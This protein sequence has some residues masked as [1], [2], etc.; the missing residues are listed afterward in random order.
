MKINVKK[1]EFYLNKGIKIFNNKNDF[2]FKR[3]EIDINILIGLGKFFSYK[4]KSACYWEL[5]LKEPKY[6]F[7][8]KDIYNF[9]KMTY[10]VAKM[11]NLHRFLCF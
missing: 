6:N 3:L 11:Q 4:I 2:D 8:P 1:S 5:F 9:L 10:L 7:A